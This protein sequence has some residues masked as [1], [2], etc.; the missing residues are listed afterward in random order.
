MT[1]L[2]IVDRELRVRARAPATYRA[3]CVGAMLAVGISTF[4]L[5]LGGNPGGGSRKGLSIFGIL[6]LATFIFCLFEGLRNTADCLSEE[7]RAGTLGFLFLTDLKGYD[8][9]LGKG[10]ATTLNSLYV[11]VAILPALALPL[12]LGGVTVGEFWRLVLVLIE[13]LFVSLSIGML[14]SS[15]SRSE[16]RAWLASFLIVMFLAT[17]CPLVRY[18]PLT[19]SKFMAWLSPTT[20]FMH[21]QDSDFKSGAS[22]FWFAVAGMAALSVLSLVTASIVLPRA[23]QDIPRVGAA[24]YVWQKDLLPNAT[25]AMHRSEKRL[26]TQNPVAWLTARDRGQQFWLWF[27]VGSCGLFALLLWGISRAWAPIGV[28]FVVGAVVVHFLIA[29][30]LAFNVCYHTIEAKNSGALELLFSTPLRPREIVDGFLLG[31]RRLFFGPVVTL[32]WIETILLVS[33]VAMMALRDKEVVEAMFVLLIVGALMAVFVMDLYAVAIFGMWTALHSKKPG[34]A[35]T[36][37]VLYVLVL[38]DL[39]GLCCLTLPLTGILK[40]MVFLSYKLPLYER[41]RLLVAEPGQFTDPWKFRVPQAK[42]TRSQ[43]PSVI[44]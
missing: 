32:L 42:P 18:I 21:L 8:V 4:L 36:K 20:A 34:H 7:K 17:V 33:Q 12:L 23:W 43:L 29:V 5:M 30:W 35:F 27:L 25:H 24:P 2:P 11:L 41:F 26:L 28:G 40:N 37:T 9:V 10:I 44:E 13:T 19:P 3:R 22:A 31:Q 6:S 15:V 39:Q 14:I 1:F 38:P 16:R